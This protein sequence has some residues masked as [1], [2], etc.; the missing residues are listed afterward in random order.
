MHRIDGQDKSP[1]QMVSADL[2]AHYWRPKAE[3]VA[4]KATASQDLR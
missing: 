1:M 4:L 2:L 3:L